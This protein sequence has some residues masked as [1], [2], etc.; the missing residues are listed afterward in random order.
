DLP[1]E[2][3]VEDLAPQ[4]D[5]SRNPLTQISFALQNETDGP[6]ELAGTDT[7]PIQLDAPTAKFDLSV[8]LSTDPNGGLV[9]T[10]TYASEIY[11]GVTIKRFADHFNQALHSAAEN[12]YIRISEITLLTEGEI[13]KQLH[14][15]NETEFDF[16]HE[17]CVHELIHE[18]SVK[19]PDAVAVTCEGESLTYR[20]LNSRANQLAHHLQTANVARGAL[21]GI[22]ME[23]SL[24]LMVAIL[25][26]LK[27]GAAYVPLDPDWPQARL[28]F[29]LGE[30]NAK[31]ILTQDNMTERLSGVET[32]TI[33]LDS[34][35]F[36]IGRNSVAP[37]SRSATP[38]DLA[39]IIYTSGSTGT[40]KG[41][42]IEHRSL[43]NYLHWAKDAYP[44]TGE[45]GS[46]LFSP[47]SFDLTVTSLFVPLLQGNRIDVVRANRA[48]SIQY[49]AELL[50]RGNSYSFLKATPTYLDALL[51]HISALGGTAL[52]STIVVGGEALPSWLAEKAREICQGRVSV[53]N[54]YG[55]TETT[56]GCTT[57]NVSIDTIGK[58]IPIGGPIAN[59]EVFVMDRF[60]GLAPVGVPGELW[61]GG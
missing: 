49:V 5:L 48:E 36:R 47:V 24:E 10:L 59:T 20:E 12:P 34:E 60:G 30:V 29:V 46:I 50:T 39:Y 13:S 18:Q 52:L 56:V 32:E 58:D 3:L 4:R 40:P 16:P 14:E 33:R 21:V 55:P 17:R 19:T 15:W 45:C 38:D 22:F 23:R 8:T 51:E 27:A 43:V 26:T 41:V 1:F 9:G 28:R 57:F 25:G 54:E 31:A 53:I 37:V 2:R 35:W 44:S 6:W 42:M 61:I 11:N 7:Q